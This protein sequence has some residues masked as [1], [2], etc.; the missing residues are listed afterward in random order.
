[1]LNYSCQSLAGRRQLDNIRGRYGQNSTH[2]LSRPAGMPA[3]TGG[4]HNRVVNKHI[5]TLFYTSNNP[6]NRHEL[7]DN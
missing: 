5:F 7:P 3:E 2:S 4:L 1:M 6:L